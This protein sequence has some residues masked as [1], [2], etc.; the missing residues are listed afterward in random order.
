MF[1]FPYS[2]LVRR[3]IDKTA[4]C[5]PFDCRNMRRREALILFRI[6]DTNQMLMKFLICNSG[7][8]PAKLQ[9]SRGVPTQ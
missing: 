4:R 3:M 7:R 5:F 8:L 9:Q 6:E 2:M 1:C